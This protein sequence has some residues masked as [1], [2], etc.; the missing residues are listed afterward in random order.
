MKKSVAIIA[1]AVIFALSTLALAAGSD[2]SGSVPAASSS[3]SQASASSMASESTGDP[4]SDVGWLLLT[5]AAA[6]GFAVAVIL[7][8]K[9]KKAGK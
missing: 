9:R 2:P 6:A 7:Q 3:S 4:F 8:V 5:G 1:M